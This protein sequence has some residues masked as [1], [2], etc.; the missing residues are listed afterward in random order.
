MKQAWTETS[1]ACCRCADFV[2]LNKVDMLKAG[3]VED[4]SQIAASLNPLA[5]VPLTHCTDALVWLKWL[6]WLSPWRCLLLVAKLPL[7]ISNRHRSLRLEACGWGR[8]A[9]STHTHRFMLHHHSMRDEELG[10]GQDCLVNQRRLHQGLH[11]MS[12]RLS[13]GLHLQIISCE[14]GR[15]SLDE[16][17]GPEAK[18]FIAGL[19]TEGHHRGAVAA[20]KSQQLKEVISFC[21]R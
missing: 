4:L 11:K 9:A 5:K 17:F 13:L 7:S 2:L 14:R 12:E 1:I 8:Y 20:V 18:G 16:V 10:L 6:I 19:N 3:E 21:L 15:I